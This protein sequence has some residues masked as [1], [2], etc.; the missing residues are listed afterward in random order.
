M[1]RE[2]NKY[3][4][5]AEN[6][7]GAKAYLYGNKMRELIK[8]FDSEFCRDGFKINIYYNNYDL[9]AKEVKTTFR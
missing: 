2:M 9:L 7:Q 6:E 5:R 8:R 4:L 1:N 3:E